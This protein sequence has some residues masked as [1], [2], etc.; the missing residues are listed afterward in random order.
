MAAKLTD[1]QKLEIELLKLERQ[2]KDSRPAE[3]AEDNFL[4]ALNVTA[5]EVWEESEVEEDGTDA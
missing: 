2:V 1:K 3:E 5:A 4:D